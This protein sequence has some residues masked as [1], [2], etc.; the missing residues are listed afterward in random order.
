MI[1]KAIFCSERIEIRN[2][3]KTTVDPVKGVY[4]QHNPPNNLL[5]L[6]AVN[7]Q[8]YHEACR[9]FYRY[10]TFIFRC[11]EALPVFLIAIGKKNAHFLKSVEWKRDS[12]LRENNMD[13]IKSYITQNGDQSQEGQEI[14]VWNNEEQFMALSEAIMFPRPVY[15][16]S[17]DRPLRL[18][19]DDVSPL[20]GYE[21]YIL[22]LD[23]YQDTEKKRKCEAGYEMRTRRVK[24]NDPKRIAAL[25]ALMEW[26]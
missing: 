13:T 21:R 6:I 11:E 5:S 23:C 4:L 22:S 20:D 17:T 8:V 2:I 9:I 24:D 7:R 3:R 14:D 12:G 25:Q 16:G 19:S 1:Y 10:N 26:R 15:R 18:D